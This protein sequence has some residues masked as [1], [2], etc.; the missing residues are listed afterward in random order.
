[1]TSLHQP[2]DI[3]RVLTPELPDVARGVDGDSLADHLYLENC[4][5]RL[6]TLD[7][8]ATDLSV[9]LTAL[10]AVTMSLDGLTYRLTLKKGM[11]FHCGAEV[12]ANDAVETIRRI[13]RRQDSTSQLHRYVA[14]DRD[15]GH[16]AALYSVSRYRFE[17]RLTRR[18][19]DLLARL[20]LPE[21]ALRHDGKT[22]FSGPWRPAPDAIPVGI[23]LVVHDKHPEAAQCQYKGVIWETTQD[24]PDLTSP[25]DDAVL[26]VYPGTRFKSPPEELLTDEICRPL[27]SGASIL[28]K[29]DAP[30]EDAAELKARV[31]AA[32]KVAF[33]NP[34]LWR[35]TP[36]DSLVPRGHVLHTAFLPEAAP[37]RD[38][39]MHLTLE[40]GAAPTLVPDRAL[41]EFCRAALETQNLDVAL[42][43]T[44]AGQLAKGL[45]GRLKVVHYDHPADAYTPIAQL[46]SDA[47]AVQSSW[48]DERSGKI[49]RAVVEFC[50]T[51]LKSQGYAPFLAVPH[52]LR[53]NRNVRTRETS[54][55]VHFSDVRQSDDRLRKSRMKEATLKSLGAALQ[56]FVHDVRR[57]FSMVQGLVGLMEAADSPS[58]LRELA[59]RYLPD[60]RST[61]LGVDRLIQDIL[62][63][64]SDTEPVREATPI[65]VLIDRVLRET[66]ATPREGLRGLSFVYKFAHTHTVDADP[67][68][69]ARVIA[70]LLINAVEALPPAAAGDQLIWFQTEEDQEHGMMLVTLGNTGS[71]IPEEL[72]SGLFDRF[73]TEGKKRGTGLGLAIVKKIV[74]DHGG[75]V[76]CESDRELGTRFIFTLPTATSLDA[77]PSVA[78]PAKPTD[79]RVTR[80]TTPRIY[81]EDSGGDD[82]I[83]PSTLASARVLIVDDS[84]IY[85]E[86]IQE[87]MTEDEL[88][89]S[90]VTFV[91]ASCA[92]EALAAAARDSF[93]VAIVDVDLGAHSESGLAVVRLLRARDPSLKIC[94]HSNGAPFELQKRASDAG[95]DLFL[96]KPMARDHL[97]R[98][99]NSVDRSAPLAAAVDKS[100]EL[101]LVA[102]VD[103]DALIL[104]TW[105]ALPGYHWLTFESP[106]ALLTALAT[107]RHLLSALT[108]VVTDFTFPMSD[109]GSALNGADLASALASR[110][111]ELPIFLAT[112]RPLGRLPPGVTGKWPKEAK[113]AV[114][115]LAKLVTN[116]KLR[117]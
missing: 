40:I 116:Q 75:D 13:V 21:M 35:R 34:S 57:P 64:G 61:V 50:Q 4:A 17:I 92:T 49:P 74:N 111:P 12:T 52:V 15:G 53:C 8:Q 65:W 80:R 9:R 94:V 41:K 33:G 86:M 23:R 47:S 54:G 106:E 26:A 89:A 39:K 31:A 5:D 56:M 99:L 112:D 2:A 19:P 38:R 105:E 97:L 114:L 71:F 32:A 36:L 76:W 87:L 68:K 43:D 84:T 100:T 11:F 88:V 27:A 7:A 91:T 6:T 10:D 58:R 62:E 109:H 104:E 67:G 96:P 73:F 18:L 29:L 42:V 82:S 102:V 24:L 98:L 77:G 59:V 22:C 103:D 66:F 48:E 95:A 113:L 60:L 79:V 108:C 83:D 46:G 55:L 20:S 3:L 25:G 63:I 69:V 107:Q 117:L 30:R 72:L 45:R 44:Q 51:L 110:R 16:G 81:T 101:P 1:M 70:N 85:V 93:D 78:L 37:S 14:K 28:V 115:E 90:G